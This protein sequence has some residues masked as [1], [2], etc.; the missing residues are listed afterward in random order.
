[1]KSYEGVTRNRI[2]PNSHVIIRVDGKAFHTFTKRLTRPFCKE[3]R[4]AF[5]Q[6]GVLVSQEMQ[7]FKIFYHQSDEISFYLN[8]LNSNETQPWFKNEVQKLASV[9]ASLFTAHFNNRLKIIG[10]D[11][12]PAIF[13]ARVFSVPNEA[14]VANYFLWRS[15]DCYRNAISMIAQSNYSHKELHGIPTRLL[16]DK[17]YSEKGVDVY[18]DDF[19]HYLNGHY[20]KGD[21]DMEGM[22]LPVSSSSYDVW[23]NLIKEANKPKEVEL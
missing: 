12:P 4:Q 16:V 18:G 20:W 17:L 2:C 13:D 1:M 8:D 10:V 15:Q 23:A 19:V 11:K 9:T 5:F 6:A 7:N 22:G 21:F 3:L 14:E